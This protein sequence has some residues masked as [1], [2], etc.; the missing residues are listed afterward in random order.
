MKISSSFNNFFSA[1]A[2]SRLSM[3]LLL[4]MLYDIG[5]AQFLSLFDDGLFSTSNDDRNQ[6]AER[7]VKI[8]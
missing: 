8:A 3:A 6:S 2:I 7:I 1:I 5:F 4:Y